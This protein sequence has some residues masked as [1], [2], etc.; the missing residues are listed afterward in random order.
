MELL[1]PAGNLVKLKTAFQYGA[2]ACYMGLDSFSL[3][4]GDKDFG[5]EELEYAIKYAQEQGKKLYITANIFP[6]NKDLEKL[7]DFFIWLDNKNIDGIIVS[8]LGAFSIAKELAK[9]TPLHISTQA[10]ILNYATVHEWE[11]LGAERVILARELPLEDIKEIADKTNIEIEVFCHGAMCMSY[12]GRCLISSYMADRNANKGDCPQPCRWKYVLEEEKRPGEYYS[13][14]EDDKGSYIFNSKDLCLINRLKELENA[15]VD[16]IKIEGRMKSE[17]Y[18]AT[19]C[20]AYRNEL[21]GVGEN[22]FEELQK[23]SHREY[24]EGPMFGNK[25][26]EVRGTSSYIREATVLGVVLSSDGVFI[27]CEQRNKFSAGDKLEIMTP[28]SNYIIDDCELYDE[29]GKAV[30]TLPHP[31]QKFYIKS[32]LSIPTNSFI[33]TTFS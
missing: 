25:D 15:G 20:K 21:D 1:A 29:N 13:I 33:R 23:V 11:K 5:Y 8:D 24:T 27:E 10:N 30:E 28:D 4:R 3:R 19:V 2:D 12:S 22:N 9:N 31:Q 14:E 32:N 18:L 26:L 7:K 17:Y 16:S 6:Y